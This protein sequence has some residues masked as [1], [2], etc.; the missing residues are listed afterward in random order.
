MVHLSSFVLLFYEQK[1]MQSLDDAGY[2]PQ[3]VSICN[4]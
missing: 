3:P 1:Q 4:V 2:L